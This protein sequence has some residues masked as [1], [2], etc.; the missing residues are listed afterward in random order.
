MRIS[1]FSLTLTAFAHSIM[2][3]NYRSSC[4]APR[5]YGY[6]LRARCGNGQGAYTEPYIMLNDCIGND[7]GTLVHRKNG[8]AFK[9]CEG[10]QLIGTVIQSECDHSNGEVQDASIDTSM[11]DEERY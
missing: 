5:L 7:Q 4:E 2:A 9:T 10:A 1:S 8:N 3:Q 6:E 11:F